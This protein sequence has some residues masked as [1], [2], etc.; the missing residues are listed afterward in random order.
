[1]SKRKPAP[2][3]REG[4]R[5]SEPEQD[6][7]SVERRAEALRLAAT[8]LNYRQ[9]GDALGVTKKAA[10]ALV[11]DSLEER[12]EEMR[13][14]AAQ[15]IALA[16]EKLDTLTRAAVRIVYEG[17]SDVVRLQAIDRVLE[18]E[19]RR[20]ALLGL[21]APKREQHEHNIDG[22]MAFFQAVLSSRVSG[23]STARLLDAEADCG[24]ELPALA[25]PADEDDR[26]ATP[27]TDE[28]MAEL[29]AAA[30]KANE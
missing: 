8:G 3:K 7:Q 14:D 23:G 9:I 16:C 21:D 24:R 25:P 30:E 15:A 1:M 13:Q 11:Q 4:A 28:D 12:R 10:W 22:L 6:M 27:Q 29:E 20:A 26:A 5:G 17:K 18:I 2:G 19:K